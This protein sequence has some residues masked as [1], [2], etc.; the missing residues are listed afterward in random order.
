MPTVIVPASMRRAPDRVISALTMPSSTVDDKTHHRSRRQRLQHVVQQA[1]HAAGEDFLLALL[2]AV[3]LHDAH[4]GERFGEPPGDFGVQSWSGRGRWA[5]WCRTPCSE[6][7]PKT[8]R[9]AKAT[10]GHERAD[11]QKNDERE[12]RRHDAAD[13]FDQT[14]ADQISQ[15]FDVA[16]DAR[17][18]RAGLVGV[19]EGH[20]QAADVRLHLA[21]QVG[22]HALRGLREKLRERVGSRALAPRR[23]PA[24]RVRAEAGA[25]SRAC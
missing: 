6:P 20:R 16:H 19:V 14:G 15:A 22:D 3:A 10:Q 7:R 25:E 13:Q 4:A 9:I 2:G 12:D 17:D 1:L 11:A 8:T 24:A 21:A 5:G 23:L 18:E